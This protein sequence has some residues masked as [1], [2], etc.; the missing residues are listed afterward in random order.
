MKKIFLLLSLVFCVSINASAAESVS[1][2]SPSQKVKVELFLTTEGQAAYRAY[3]KDKLVLEDSLLGFEFA[4]SK[5]LAKNLKIL[6]TKKSNFNQTW[7]QPW[8]EEHF[9]K[10][11][12]SQLNVSLAESGDQKRKINLIFRV[13]DDGIGFRYE[14]PEQASLKNIEITDELTQFNLVEDAAA[15]WTPA[16]AGE[17]YEYLYR[18]TLVSKMGLVLTPITL[19]SASGL[20]FSIHE[21]AL[22]NFS[23]MNLASAASGGKIKASLVPLTKTSDVK[24]KLTAPAV[25]PWRTVQIAENVSDL[26]TNY[27]TLNLNEPNKLGDVSWVK[28]GKYVGVWWEMHLEKTSWGTGAKHG[29]TTENTKKY[30]DF[31]TKYGFFGVLV[32]GWNAGWDGEW[33]K[34]GD[35]FNFTTP[36][37][38]YDINE[39]SRYG[40][41]KGV[42]VIGHHETGSGVDNYERQ[43]EP[44]YKFLADHGMHAVKT[45]YVESGELLTNGFYHHGQRFVQHQQKV[46]DMAAKYHVMLDAHETV[47]DTGERRTYPNFVS[48]EVARGQEYNAWSKDGGNPP[49][50]LTIL[51]FT[52]LLA[53]PMDYTPGIFQLTLPSRPL[54]QVNA[55]LANQLALYVVIYSP[56][57]M[58]ADLP[59]NYEKHLDAFQFIRD[60]PADWETTRVLEGEIGQY[61]TFAR[62]ERNGTNWFVGGVTNEYA[63]TSTINL[64]FLDAGKQYKA[65]IYK[66][67][68]NANYLLN[69][70]AYE[71]EERT[72]TSKDQLSIGLAAGGG[73]AISLIQIK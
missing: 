9:I 19:K 61:A 41:E 55:T 70:E 64:S 2:V 51:P 31:A 53:G 32:E 48:R 14:F 69:P 62:K 16:L 10:N 54:N 4:N 22:H 56:V 72:V 36:T 1:V 7:E 71:I 26:V 6:S 11:N 17:Q 58:V 65:R 59:E 49:N 33:W 34:N 46:I 47:K 66:D 20:Y 37:P 43:L 50:H 35:K 18:N 73:V 15:W 5:A 29:A 44:A 28:P 25:T 68:K 45:G 52:R 57:Q 30:I 63:R 40:K 3:Y 38:D 27:L 67:A 24:V 13:Y 12:Y 39:L 23:T 8:G 21:A 60:V 42:F